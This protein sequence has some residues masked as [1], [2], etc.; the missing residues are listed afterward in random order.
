MWYVVNGKND[1]RDSILVNRNKFHVAFS[2]LASWHLKTLCS[3]CELINNVSE[4]FCKSRKVTVCASSVC[5]KTFL[6][7]SKRAS[8]F[9][10]LV[11][12]KNSCKKKWE[13]KTCHLILS[14]NI[15]LKSN[16]GKIWLV[17]MDEI[18]TDGDMKLGK[19]QNLEFR[20]AGYIQTFVNNWGYAQPRVGVSSTS[21]Q[22]SKPCLPCCRAEEVHDAAGPFS[23]LLP[24]SHSNP[25]GDPKLYAEPPLTPPSWNDLLGTTW[26]HWVFMLQQLL[27]SL[28]S[29]CY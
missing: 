10:G 29:Q 5:Q 3:T 20:T 4:E 26:A 9:W 11:T 19:Q 24:V 12:W 25:D 7:Q 15:H 6:V 14:L 18:F 23:P 21:T 8:L 13:I 22:C 16:F 1:F 2:S 28:L 27:S 17:W